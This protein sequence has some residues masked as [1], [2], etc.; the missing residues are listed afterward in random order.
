VTV[1]LPSVGVDPKSLGGLIED[2]QAVQ[3]AASSIG[4][5]TLVLGHSYGGMVIGSA[6]FPA[7]VRRLVFLGAFMPEAGRSLVSYLPPG[8]LPPFVKARD[9]GCSEVAMEVA[10]AC[11]YADCD[12]AT[13]Q[14]AKDRLALHSTAA[15]TTPAPTCTWQERP[16]TYIVLTQDRVIPVAAQQQMAAQANDQVEFESSHSP[17]LSRPDELAELL[18]K[19]A[20]R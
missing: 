2:V 3:V 9:D 4:G 10:D 6:T 1:A 18:A 7:S 14:R 12:A 16:S 11:F 13:R 5:P 15:I 8:P 19:L 20:L 17:M